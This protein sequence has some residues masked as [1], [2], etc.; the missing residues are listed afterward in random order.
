MPEY[1]RVYTLCVGAPC[2]RSRILALLM[3]K[4]RHCSA[5]H[6]P[7]NSQLLQLQLLLLLGLLLLL[8]CP[9]DHHSTPPAPP[10]PFSSPSLP[11]LSPSSVDDAD[12]EHGGKIGGGGTSML[13]TA[14][15]II[16]NM[17]G[18][19]VL[20]LPRAVRVRFQAKHPLPRACL[21]VPATN[22]NGSSS[23]LFHLQNS[24]FID[25]H[26]PTPTHGHTEH[27]VGGGLGPAAG[28]HL[29]E[30][31]LRRTAGQAARY[32]PQD[33][34]WSGGVLIFFFFS[35]VGLIL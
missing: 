1:I 20:G 8:S 15:L 19:G 30:H 10:P 17:L 29:Y 11:P 4:G 3:P 32:P 33:Q 35:V 26:S 25:P 31:L 24:Q 12:A 13:S 18:A 2:P 28:C 14:T 5:T 23:L 21:L 22:S 7:T 9:I 16:A 6:V 27:G 34:G